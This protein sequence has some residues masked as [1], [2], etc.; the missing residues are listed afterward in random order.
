MEI[1]AW[2]TEMSDDAGLGELR[3]TEELVKLDAAM[4]TARGYIKHL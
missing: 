4:E 1:T 2:L 3:D